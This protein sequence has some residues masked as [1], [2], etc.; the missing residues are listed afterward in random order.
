M[1]NPDLH[2]DP[3]LVAERDAKLR[4]LGPQPPWWR[5]FAR[6][7]WKRARATIMATDVTF[8][9]AIYRNIYSA[10]EI[11][12]I[13]NRPSPFASMMKAP[14]P[15][16]AESFKYTVTRHSPSGLPEP[17]QGKCKHCGHYALIHGADKCHHVAEYEGNGSAP[18]SAYCGCKGFEVA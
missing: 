11:E 6:R 13:R 16:D 7:R 15:F 17:G 4:E 5:V 18:L 2:S 3:K 9:A 1:V 14:Y 8:V 10:A 12:A